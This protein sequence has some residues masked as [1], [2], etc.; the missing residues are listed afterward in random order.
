M[1]TRATLLETLRSSGQDVVERLRALP[2]AEFERG[3]YENGWNGRQIL[4]HIASIEWSYPR[5]LEIARQGASGMALAEPVRRTAPGEAPG[6][7]TTAPQGGMDAYNARQVERRAG[8][9]VTDL[10]DEFERNRAT[11]IAAVETTEP[12]LFDRPVRS[13][14]GL[15]GT[16]A[17]VLREVAVVHVLGHV[18]D[19][20]GA[21]NASGDG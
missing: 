4:A 7:P 11:L 6:V 21:A 5:L 2:G 15:T 13:A 17:D 1:D 8:A 19:I 14:G 20:T 18:N 3:R 9:S 12:D 10:I 16:L